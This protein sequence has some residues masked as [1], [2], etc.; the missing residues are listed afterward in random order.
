MRMKE[1]LQRLAAAAGTIGGKMRTPVAPGV[2]SPAKTVLDVAHFVVLALSVAL[3]VFISYDTFRNIP[4]L[5]SA[6]YMRFQLV[7]CWVFIADFFL[8]LALT[9]RGD[10]RRYIRSRWL[11][12][13]LSI[14]FLNIINSYH[15]A[16]PEESLSFIRFIPLARGALALVIVL[17][18]ISSNRIT[19]LFMSYLSIVILTT[20][21]AALVF[22]DLEHP[23][24]PSV[25]SHADAFVWCSLQTTTLGSSVMPVTVTGKIIAVIL[26][27]M[28]V[29]M[30]PLFTVYLSSLILRRH[31]LLNLLNITTQSV[32]T[33][34]AASQNSPPQGEK[35]AQT[36]KKA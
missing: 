14:P 34:A 20:Y 28:G 30:F 32:K 6:H 13:L 18:Y 29:I 27:G 36:Q 8:E 21:F 16:V 11:Y 24:N 10:R 9:P 7:V 22:Y 1:G 4:F 17:Q 31:N 5:E 33:P 2:K 25:R 35:V 26:S 19:G 23:V 15:I 12:L 3:I